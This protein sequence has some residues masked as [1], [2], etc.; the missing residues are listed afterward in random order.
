MTS[1]WYDARFLAARCTSTSARAD[2]ARLQ[3][4]RMGGERIDTSGPVDQP[5]LVTVTAKLVGQA[6]EAIERDS[7]PSIRPVDQ[8]PDASRY[9]SSKA[10]PKA[11][12]SHLA[13]GEWIGKGMT[14]P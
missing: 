14:K 5:D 13:E 7:S 9:L 8:C 6:G 12:T 1:A 2:K 11:M 10:S 3:P 4:I